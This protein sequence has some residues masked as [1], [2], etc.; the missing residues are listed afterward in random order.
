MRALNLKNFV[1]HEDL[2][3]VTVNYI[4]LQPHLLEK[5]DRIL[6][7]TEVGNMRSCFEDLAAYVKPMVLTYHLIHIKLAKMLSMSNS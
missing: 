1:K 6:E 7:R 5:A 4:V 2:W 3:L